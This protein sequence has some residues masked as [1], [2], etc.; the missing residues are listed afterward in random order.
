MVI[1]CGLMR[2]I[3]SAFINGEHEK[4]MLTLHHPHS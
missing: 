4:G 2:G 1:T 3:E